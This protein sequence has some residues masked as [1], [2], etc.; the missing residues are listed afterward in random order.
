M[1]TL[2]A[3]L[4][5]CPCSW[6]RALRFP[7]TQKAFFWW[8]GTVLGESVVWGRGGLWV[9]GLQEPPDHLSPQPRTYQL[10]QRGRRGGG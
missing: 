2:L 7:Q 10:K 3:W 9:G 5:N 1:V 4:Q 8:A 6:W